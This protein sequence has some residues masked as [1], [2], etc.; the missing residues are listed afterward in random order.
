MLQ[1]VLSN[2]ELITD[3]TFTISKNVTWA[4]GYVENGGNSSANG[5][6]KKYK[7]S[8]NDSFAFFSDLEPFTEYKISVEVTNDQ[9]LSNTA[10]TMWITSTAS[11]LYLS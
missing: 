7:V 10:S 1:H 4:D 5:T 11:E 3:Y 6:I 8:S 2:C 9:Q